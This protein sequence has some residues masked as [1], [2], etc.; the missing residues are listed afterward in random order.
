MVESALT[1][2]KF[3]YGAEKLVSEE[4]KLAGRSVEAE[5]L[6]NGAPYKA[7]RDCIDLLD[8]RASGT[9]FTGT[10]K[11]RQLAEQL[12]TMVHPGAMVMD[13]TCGMGDL[14]LAYAEG[15]PIESSLHETLISWGKQL[16]GFD[17]NPDLVRLTKAR[18]ILQARLRGGF[19]GEL[20]QSDPCFQQIQVGDMMAAKDALSVPDGF[21]FNPPFGV[22]KEVSDCSWSAGSV[23]AAA[24]FL[25]ELI[26]QKRD[27][28]P[29]SAILPEVLRCGS[30]YE[31]FREYLK[32]LNLSGT[33]LSL[34]RFDPWTDVDV[35]STLIQVSE[36]GRIWE[37]NT[38][39]KH[40][41]F[42]GDRFNVH[43]GA[44][45][46]HRH[47]NKGKW[48]RYV[49][50][51]TTPRWATAFRPTSNRRFSGTVFQAPFVVIRRTSSPSDRNRAVGAVIVADKPVAVE[52][53]L[54]V[55]LPK[56]QKLETCQ[57]LIEVL[58]TDDTNEFLNSSIRCRHLTTGV[59]TR[60]PWTMSDD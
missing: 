9:F 1:F 8:R 37:N 18:L 24:L 50:A 5:P 27:S 4:F 36:K 17:L 15:L 21:M 57:R 45:V 60:L 33:Y 12:R 20:I 42:V 41:Q 3:V 16:S 11:A 52:N 14:L 13:P 23:N 31:V 10:I 29:V 56:D 25:A 19:A 55:L 46:P 22:V 43:V 40:N 35:F 32:D 2:Q 7:F 34:G 54:I 38:K 49:C 26:A 48:H 47:G 59:V 51:K 53:H 44:V 30:R 6:L 39:Q 28:S 58:R